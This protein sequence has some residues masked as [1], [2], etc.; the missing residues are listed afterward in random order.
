MPLTRLPDPECVL[1]GPRTRLERP[2]GLL[3]A[4]LA[5]GRARDSVAGL[6]PYDGPCA[7]G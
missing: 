3:G 7:Y 1:S 2:D 6:P 5:R 4:N